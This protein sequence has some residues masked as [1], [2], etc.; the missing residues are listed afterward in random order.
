MSVTILQDIQGAITSHLVSH[1][2]LIPLISGRVHS[3]LP[4]PVVFPC[5]RMQRLSG[6]LA[7]PANA[8]GIVGPARADLSVHCWAQSPQQAERLAETARAV[9]HDMPNH[10]AVLAVRESGAPRYVADDSRPEVVH[11]FVLSFSV[12]Y[13]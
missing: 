8:D 4:D 12:H 10:I 5:M 13:R 7:A 2:A 6:G 1:P 11:R 9:F 3:V